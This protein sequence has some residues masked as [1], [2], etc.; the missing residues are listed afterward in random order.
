METLNNVTYVYKK[1]YSILLEK[2][3]SYDVYPPYHYSV[4]L[5]KSFYLH[6]M[7]IITIIITVILTKKGEHSRQQIITLLAAF[8]VP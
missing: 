8:P 4:P 7:T 1:G 5:S 2:I 3:L 6:I